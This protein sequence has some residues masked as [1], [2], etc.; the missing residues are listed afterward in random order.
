MKEPSRYIHA[1]PQLR[2]VLATLRSHRKQIFMATNSH[3]EYLELAMGATLGPD[4][5]NQ[6][7]L[8]LVNCNKPLW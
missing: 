6:F 7:D 8:V 2:N 4:W 5:K 3:L 1:Q